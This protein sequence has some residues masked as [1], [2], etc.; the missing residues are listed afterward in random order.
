MQYGASSLPAADSQNLLHISRQNGDTSLLAAD[1]QNPLHISR[2]NGDTSLPATDGQHLLPVLGH[3]VAIDGVHE[4]LKRYSKVIFIQRL[5]AYI[6]P[7]LLA[8]NMEWKHYTSNQRYV[9]PAMPW[10]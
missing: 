6:L 4:P 5:R 8:R 1:S 10:F 2:R 3:S 9:Q 7:V